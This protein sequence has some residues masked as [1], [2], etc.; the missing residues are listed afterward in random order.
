MV[1]LPQAPAIMG[2][3]GVEVTRCGGSSPTDDDV[4]EGSVRAV[5]GHAAAPPLTGGCKAPP[6]SERRAPAAPPSRGPF[7]GGAWT[8]VGAGGSSSE[9]RALADKRWQQWVAAW[10]GGSVGGRRCGRAAV[11]MTTWAA[12]APVGVGALCVHVCG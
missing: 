10:V 11:V 9:Q 6:S 1:R 5:S 2:R 12:A 8:S 4:Q 3:G 7:G